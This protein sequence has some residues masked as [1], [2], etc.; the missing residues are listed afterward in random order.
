M[1]LWLFFF[2]VYYSV[3]LYTVLI[4]REASERASKFGIIR[5]CLQHDGN[6]CDPLMGINGMNA[7]F[8]GLR[9]IG[10]TVIIIIIMHV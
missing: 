3:C 10:I 1:I 6:V 9:D 8:T 2:L 4:P 5:L 7:H